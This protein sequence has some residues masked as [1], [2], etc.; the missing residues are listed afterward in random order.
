MQFLLHVTC[1]CIAFFF[2]FFPKHFFLLHPFLLLSPLYFLTMAPQKSTLL[3]NPIS[4]CGSSSSS[5]LPSLLAKDKFPKRI[6]MRTLVTRRFI[7]N[8]KSFCLTFQ[9]CLFPKR[10]ALRVG[11]L[12]TR[13]PRGVSVCLYWSSTTTYKPSIALFPSLL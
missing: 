11:N 1:S 7:R 13:N 2:F 8:T 3:K 6:L 4:H 12:F 9:T 10:L 5:S